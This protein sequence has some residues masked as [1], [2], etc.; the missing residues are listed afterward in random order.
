MMKNLNFVFIVLV[1]LSYFQPFKMHAQQAIEPTHIEDAEWANAEPE[2]LLNLIATVD[3]EVRKTA[4]YQSLRHRSV[5][6]RLAAA[7]RLFGLK[8]AES[9]ALFV[10]AYDNASL[11]FAGG[12]ESSIE[13]RRLLS[14]LA[15]NLAL[16]LNVSTDS[17]RPDWEANVVQK[18]RESLQ[19]PLD[20]SKPIG[21]TQDHSYNDKLQDSGSLPA[22]HKQTSGTG[23]SSQSG[24]EQPSLP[25]LWPVVL[26]MIMAAFGLLWLLFKRR[27]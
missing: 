12:T 13:Q 1:L 21:A 14:Q 4:L 7:K 9:I 19:G 17:K 2:L 3:I 5:A 18:A 27:K 23:N 11:P 8:D 26:G 25:T 22:S 16:A 24:N 10:G 15:N 6:V 20:P